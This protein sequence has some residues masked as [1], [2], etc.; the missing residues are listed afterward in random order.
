MRT[1]SSTEGFPPARRRIPGAIALLAC[2]AA[3]SVTVALPLDITAQSKPAITPA[4]YA[5]W[6][7]L[8]AGVLSPDGARLAVS[9]RRV[10]GTSE[11]RVHDTAPAGAEPRVIAEGGS[12]AF[13]SD[14]RWLA[15]SIGYSEAERE[16]HGSDEEPLRDK[17][18]LLELASGDEVVVEAIDGFAFDDTGGYL[19]L[20]GYPAEERDAADLIVRDLARGTSIN[21]GNVAEYAWQDGAPRLA[22]TLDTENGAGNGI[23]LYDAASGTLVSLASQDGATFT[24]P[25]WR[26]DAADLAVLRSEDDEAFEEPTHVIVAWRGLDDDIPGALSFDHRALADFGAGTDMRVVEHR[27]PGWSDDGSMIFFGM[28][29]WTAEPE[30]DDAAEGTPEATAGEGQGGT[31]DNPNETGETTGGTGETGEGTEASP[32]DAEEPEPADVDVWHARDERINPMQKLQEQRDRRASYLAVWHLDGG[33]RFVR[34]GTDL[35]ESVELLAGQRHATE[36]DRKPYMFDGMFGR[37]WYDLDLI[38]VATGERTRVVDRVR[39]I[40]GGSAGGKHLLYFK[41]D[42]H[43]AYA[44]ATG[45]HVDLTSSLPSTF[46]NE[47]YDFPTEQ[48]PSWGTAGWAEDDEAVL[49]YDRW[50]IWS[51]SPD[52]SGAV[53][54]TGGADS[55]IRYRLVRLDRDP[56]SFGGSDDPI[57]LDQPL[58]L[59]MYGEWTKKSGYARLAPAGARLGDDRAAPGEPSVPARSPEPLVWLDKSV[60]R[61]AKAKDAEVYAY[62][63]QSF[64]DSPDYFVGGA[65][66]AGASQTTHTNPFQTDFAWGHG[67]LVDYSCE[68]GPRM[69]A[70]LYYPAGYEQGRAYPM[71][72]YVYE[73]LSQGLHGYSVPSERSPYNPAVWTSLGYFVL[74][75]DIVYRGRM[76]GT[77]AVECIRPAVKAVTDTGRVDAA[78]V[79]LVGHSWGGYEA[80]YVPTKT[81]IFAAAVSGAALTN[82]FSMFG[83]IHWNQGLP[84]SSHFETGQARMDVPYW[85]DMEAYV[86]ES[87]VMGVPDLETPMLMAFGDA[88]GTVDW[89]QGVEM[90]NY[91]RRAGKQFVMLVYANENHSNREKK[92]QLDYHRRILEWFGHYLKGEPATDW[93]TEGVSVIERNDEIGGGRRGGRGGDGGGGRR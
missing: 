18:G 52:G 59:S 78:R 83:T 45:E 88:D 84:E 92:N 48:K 22:M 80:A 53:R 16:A 28:R 31:G 73:K 50:D 27:A 44:I 2:A 46:V 81:D 9:I 89:H 75:P 55:A 13:S 57:D 49:L 19:L 41:N 6:E 8:G 70:A 17:V 82:F 63:V 25:T 26:E 61:L 23:Q 56:F 42:Q 87:P 51:V 76:P 39:Y 90:Y 33:N 86:R 34:I 7:S 20:R 38:D 36:T 4:D 54:L 66:L 30:G 71:I 40:S 14:S 11:L 29:E 24:Q 5:Q 74:E 60:G 85:D 15:Y 3:L 43:W 64:D 32:D 10:E 12:P 1:T 21:F 35:A 91:A 69:Q 65:D 58:T 72:T 68:F 62:V 79:G 37:E 47:D 77:P 93:I 67:E